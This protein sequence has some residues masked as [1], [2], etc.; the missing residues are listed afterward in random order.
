MN[1]KELFDAVL[2]YADRS[3]STVTAAA[4]K[5]FYKIVESRINRVLRIRQQ[6]A[7][8]TIQTR[9]GKFVYGLPPDFAGMRD[10]KLYNDDASKSYS[11]MPVT[12]EYMNALQ[13]ADARALYYT[14]L[15]KTIEVHPQTAGYTLEILYYQRVDAL[16]I[17]E[18][19][20]WVSDGYPD[21]YI[22]GLLVEVSSFVKDANAAQLWDARF[23]EAVDEI[24]NEDAVD[25]WS[26]PPLSMQAL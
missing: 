5:V 2:S 10:I 23:K 26:G 12:P 20:N 4:I 9:I 22:F 8:A 24:R 21:V 13:S 17:D 7:R 18:D 25:R 16:E 15:N 3:D 6:S 14:I 11:L 19:T 1:R